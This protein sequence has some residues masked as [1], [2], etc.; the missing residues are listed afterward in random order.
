M[1]VAVCKGHSHCGKHLTIEDLTKPFRMTW[2]PHHYRITTSS[3]E[4]PWILLKIK[5]TIKNHKY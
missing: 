5:W 4:S 3:E 2:Q 1:V